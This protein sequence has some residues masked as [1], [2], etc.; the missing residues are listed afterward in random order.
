VISISS[1][2]RVSVLSL[3]GRGH[4]RE[5]YSLKL[6]VIQFKNSTDVCHFSLRTHPSAPSWDGASKLVFSALTRLT[7][8]YVLTDTKVFTERGS[9]LELLDRTDT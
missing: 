7:L 3:F 1:L 9:M 8:N 2:L 5:I 6:R 4:V